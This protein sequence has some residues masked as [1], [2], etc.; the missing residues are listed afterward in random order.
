MRKY[1]KNLYRAL[2]GKSSSSQVDDLLDF[3]ST[4]RDKFSPGILRFSSDGKGIKN[5]IA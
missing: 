1:F 2:I 4:F 3:M 5:R